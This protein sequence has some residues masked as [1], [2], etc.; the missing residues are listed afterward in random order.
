MYFARNCLL[1]VLVLVPVLVLFL[2]LVPILVLVLLCGLV[3]V[4]V[5]VRVLLLVL[6]LVPVLVLL[7]PAVLHNALFYLARQFSKDAKDCS[8]NNITATKLVKSASRDFQYTWG[9]EEE[10]RARGSTARK[11]KLDKTYRART[12]AH[13]HNCTCCRRFR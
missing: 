11:S 6:V 13:T 2:V 7:V 5:L 12:H 8:E 4:L 10:E 9:G 1:V 3:H